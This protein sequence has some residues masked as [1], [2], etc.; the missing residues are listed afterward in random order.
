MSGLRYQCW[1]PDLG[2]EEDDATIVH[3]ANDWFSPEDAVDQYVESR[4][5]HW[6]S[7]QGPFDILI[8]ECGPEGQKYG[9]VQTFFVSVDWSP[10][11]YVTR[12]T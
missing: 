10:N 5:S 6:E 1:C 8:R 4:Y 3:L 9:P 11:F 12:K 7:P 2:I